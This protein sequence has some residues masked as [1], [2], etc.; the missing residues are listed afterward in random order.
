MAEEREPALSGEVFYG[1]ITHRGQMSV[2]CVAPGVEA[3]DGPR[4]RAW[5]WLPWADDLTKM[6]QWR[7]Q[8]G[9]LFGAI[10]AAWAEKAEVERNAERLNAKA[11]KDMA[12]MVREERDVALA[13]A[14]KIA[15]A[16]ERV[17]RARDTYHRHS[18][19]AEWEAYE[20]ALSDLK[21]A[22]GPDLRGEQEAEATS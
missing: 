5:K 16:W 6:R 3:D 2:C 15:A 22:G 1:T 21:E 12:E 10:L 14:E 20:V 9:D 7:E 13:R 17:Y 4:M 11:W 18:M 19:T 8:C